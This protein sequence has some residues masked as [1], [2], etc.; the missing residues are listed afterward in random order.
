[1]IKINVFLIVVLT[2]ICQIS[3]AG[4]IISEYSG[5]EG[6]SVQAIYDSQSDKVKFYSCQSLDGA[7]S[8]I[9]IGHSQGYSSKE[10]AS[11]RNKLRI[12]GA[13]VALLDIGIAMGTAV[14]SAIYVYSFLSSAPF[15]VATMADGAVNLAKAIGTF[16]VTPAFVAFP[17]MK[18]A[19]DLGIASLNPL[20]YWKRASLLSEDFAKS[21]LTF[22]MTQFPLE[23]LEEN[24]K[25]SL[26]NVK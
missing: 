14:V 4:S 18:A 24:F 10:L 17:A 5:D 1:M 23:K 11:L 2:S 3:N 8:C 13:G 21:D 7:Q 26:S 25:Y 6:K 19:D 9:H 22:T 12:T 20:R 16:L 15:N